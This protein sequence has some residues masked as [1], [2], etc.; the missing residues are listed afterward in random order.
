[1]RDAG[2]NPL[3]ALSRQQAGSNR[4][5]PSASFDTTLY[6]IHNPDVAAAHVGS[7]RALSAARHGR[8]PRD[9]RR[10]SDGKSSAASM[11]NTTCSTI[12]TWRPQASI[13]AR[14]S[15]SSA[16]TRGASRTR[17][18]DTAGYLA[19]Y[20][21]VAAAGV[22]PLDHYT[23][24][25]LEGGPRPVGR[26]RHARL[27]GGEPGRRRGGRQ[28]ARHYLTFGIYEGRQAVSDGLWH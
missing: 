14:T 19:H 13:R 4:R 1:M 7:A 18:F 27:S 21:D 2:Q 20:A 26:L 10:R 17:W 11:P 22:N 3:D 9:L 16:G 28:P 25:R 24:V 12:P 15:I 6:L 5:D 8:R 23:T